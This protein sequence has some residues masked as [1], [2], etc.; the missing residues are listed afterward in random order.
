ME[1]EKQASVPW[2]EAENLH[3]LSYMAYY[4]CNTLCVEKL[5]NCGWL[6]NRSYDGIQTRMR[7]ME[8]VKHKLELP[9]PNNARLFE[10]KH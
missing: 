5:L 10:S 9:N 1:N 2:S 8:K 4:G 3:L 6:N 7:L